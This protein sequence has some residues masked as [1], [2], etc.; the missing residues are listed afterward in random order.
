[1]DLKWSNKVPSVYTCVGNDGYTE[2]KTMDVGNELGYAPKWYKPPV[3][4]CFALDG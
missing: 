3:G 1:V 2:I 4:A